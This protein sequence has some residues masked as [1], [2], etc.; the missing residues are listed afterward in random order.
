[1]NINIQYEHNIIEYTYICMY[2][3]HLNDNYNCY[4]PYYNLKR[5]WVSEILDIFKFLQN[6]INIYI[7]VNSK[8]E[9]NLPNKK[10]FLFGINQITF[11]MKYK[12]LYIINLIVNLI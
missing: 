3:Q 6:S 5:G 7:Q 1:M 2:I 9:I 4:N 12:N 10:V 8:I 11:I